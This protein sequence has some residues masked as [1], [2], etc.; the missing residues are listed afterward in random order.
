MSLRRKPPE[1]PSPYGNYLATSFKMALAILLG[2]WGG[3]Q[4]D[5]WLNLA[6]PLC[7]VLLSL[8]GVALAIY[9]LIRDTSPKK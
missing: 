7:T 5:G 3:L 2:V 9:I 4:L 8:A 1:G 6:F